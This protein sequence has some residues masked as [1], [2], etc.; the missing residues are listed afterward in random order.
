[1]NIGYFSDKRSNHKGITF[2][3]DTI[4]VDKVPFEYK[5]LIKIL[6]QIS[7]TLIWMQTSIFSTKLVFFLR[8]VYLNT[9][10]TRFI[11]KKGSD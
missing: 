2:T 11:N 4:L 6:I 1:M 10:H 7:Q 5:T 9:S 8:L 3:P